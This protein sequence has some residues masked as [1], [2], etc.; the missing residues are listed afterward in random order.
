MHWKTPQIL[1]H[2]VFKIF[3]PQYRRLVMKR[4]IL[5]EREMYL[6]HQKVLPYLESG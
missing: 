2:I 5:P 6:L 1:I 4:Q 3:L